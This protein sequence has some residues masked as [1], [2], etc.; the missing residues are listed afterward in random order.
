M[1]ASKSPRSVRVAALALLGALF[2][3][4]C[5]DDNGGSSSN[6]GSGDG[7]SDSGGQTVEV[8]A[9]DFA[10]D[11]TTIEAE[12][13][14]EITVNLTNGDDTEHSFTIDDPAVE[15]EA[16]GGESAEVTFTAPD[17]SVEFYCEYHPEQM[18]GEVT[19]GGS[20]AGSSGNRSSDTSGGNG[21]YNYDD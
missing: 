5:G 15:T 3:A 12:A 6:G 4:A 8:T 19:V 20:A 17:S 16:A 2:L 1:L 7:G 9:A 10:F 11:P 14:E 18:R 21:A 13:G